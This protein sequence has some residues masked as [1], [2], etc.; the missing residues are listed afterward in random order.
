MKG[1][2]SIGLAPSL[3]CK[4]QTRLERLARDKHKLIGKI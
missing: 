3:T 2:P 4:H 1:M